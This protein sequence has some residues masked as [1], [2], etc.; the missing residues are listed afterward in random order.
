MHR[1]RQPLRPNSPSNG[2]GLR[3]TGL[4]GSVAAVFRTVATT[5]PV[6]RVR[7]VA[8][9]LRAL[10]LGAIICGLIGPGLPL[11]VFIPFTAIRQASVREALTTLEALPLAWLIAIIAMGP[12]GC[13]F[14]AL[15]ASWIRFRSS[16]LHVSRRL[17]LESALL[18]TALGGVVPISALVWGWG[19]R[20]NLLSVVPAGAASGLVCAFLVVHALRK[21]GLILAVS[22]TSSIQEP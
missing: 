2:I 12:A 18:G 14:G 19:P 20:E 11:I 3:F 6:P 13:V 8:P 17:L 15:G 16:S 4:S 9:W 10:L 21:R 5:N 1:T 7:V 22:P